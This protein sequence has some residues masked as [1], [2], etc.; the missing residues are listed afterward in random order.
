MNC[1]KNILTIFR[2]F[3]DKCLK[4]NTLQIL[5]EFGTIKFAENYKQALILSKAFIEINRQST[6]WNFC[7]SNEQI[8]PSAPRQDIRVQSAFPRTAKLENML[9]SRTNANKSFLT[10][11]FFS[12][13]FRMF[14]S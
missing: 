4:I 3:S 1:V 6:H 12:G 8:V 13:A 14:F 5:S 11:D 7:S 2:N 10:T 9:L